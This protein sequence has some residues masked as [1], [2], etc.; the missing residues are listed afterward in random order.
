MGKACSGW[1]AW[2]LCSPHTQAILHCSFWAH[3]AGFE[4]WC[5]CGSIAHPSLKRPCRLWPPGHSTASQ[6]I[7]IALHFSASPS[8]PSQLVGSPG[9]H[10]SSPCKFSSSSYF[11]HV[12]FSNLGSDEKTPTTKSKPNPRMQGKIMFLQA[13]SQR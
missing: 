10:W 12:V 2:T 13:N 1:A 6:P 8:P 5:Q 11:L 3:H 9:P 7:S 4:C